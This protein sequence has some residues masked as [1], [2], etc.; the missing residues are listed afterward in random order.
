MFWDDGLG[1][2]L[3]DPEAIGLLVVYEVL[4]ERVCE[5]GGVVVWVLSVDGLFCT[6]GAA[7]PVDRNR[8]Q[9]PPSQEQQTF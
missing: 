8:S 4:V 7:L 1:L 3:V 5:L 9:P 2:G 6:A